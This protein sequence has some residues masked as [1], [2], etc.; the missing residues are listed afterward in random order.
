[1]LRKRWLASAVFV[2]WASIPVRALGV[3]PSCADSVVV[4]NPSACGKWEPIEHCTYPVPSPETGACAGGKWP[5]GLHAVHM[6]L[7]HTG[8]V[9]IYGHSWS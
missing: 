7:K 5:Y 2:L 3:C 9:L 6:A 4:T 1:M 8:K